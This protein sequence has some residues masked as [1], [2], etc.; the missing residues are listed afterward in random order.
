LAQILEEIRTVSP[1]Q[2]DTSLLKHINATSRIKQ[3]LNIS[4]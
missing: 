1:G 4:W 2:S 3:L